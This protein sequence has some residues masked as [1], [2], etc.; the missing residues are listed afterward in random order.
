MAAI[1]ATAITHTVSEI[2]PTWT[3]PIRRTRGYD[4]L[5]MRLVEHIAIVELLALP[6]LCCRLL[7]KKTYKIVKLFSQFAIVRTRLK[8]YEKKIYFYVY[9][10]QFNV[11]E[12]Y[13]EI[14]WCFIII[15]N[16]VKYYSKKL[17][18]FL[19][20]KTKI[21]IPGILILILIDWALSPKTKER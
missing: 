9:S 11:R 15:M 18:L 13:V 16:V 6:T 12:N 20:H 10:V 2:S 3:T 5:R 4:I 8:M 1:R 17:F 7:D 21:R 14:T 19:R